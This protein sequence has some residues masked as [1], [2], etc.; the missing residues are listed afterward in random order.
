MVL[1]GEIVT[2]FLLSPLWSSIIWTLAPD[3]SSSYGLK[4]H[5]I[6][7]HR[8]QGTVFLHP[9]TMLCSWACQNHKPSV[10][11]LSS[12]IAV[13]YPLVLTVVCAVPM[14]QSLTLRI[15]SGHYCIP[16]VCS[17]DQFSIMSNFFTCDFAVMLVK[18][19]KSHPCQ[20]W[21][22]GYPQ[23]KNQNAQTASLYL[24]Q[25]GLVVV[26]WFQFYFYVLS[27]HSTGRESEKLLK[28]HF[29]MTS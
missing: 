26:C 25:K 14:L 2:L 11:S 28:I 15:A 24:W 19:V 7:W 17:N 8:I 29:L 1:M 13:S 5:K 9:G 12:L 16:K 6:C 10:L 3:I 23:P 20:K 21:S 22:R 4:L 27:L 18:T